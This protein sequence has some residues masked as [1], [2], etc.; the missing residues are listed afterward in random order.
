MAIFAKIKSFFPQINVLS[1]FPLCH[2]VLWKCFTLYMHG[3]GASKSKYHITSHHIT[4]GGRIQVPDWMIMGMEAL[5][6]RMAWDGIVTRFF[7]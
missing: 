1:F 5:L 6:H 3:V 4:Q 2:S 7:F